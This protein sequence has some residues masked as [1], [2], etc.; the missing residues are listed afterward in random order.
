MGLL[1]I[2]VFLRYNS[3]N[4]SKMK[5]FR[6]LFGSKEE[7]PEEKIREEKARSFDTLKYDGVQA[8]CVLPQIVSIMH[9]NCRMI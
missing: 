1:G 8:K 9:S 5:I 2:I 3:Y 6:A 4:T 7:T